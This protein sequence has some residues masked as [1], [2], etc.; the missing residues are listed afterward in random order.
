MSMQPT[1]REAAGALRGRRA[2]LG[3][4]DIH[5]GDDIHPGSQDIGKHR[6]THAY[7]RVYDDGAK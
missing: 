2:G 6:I 7:R 1:A 4:V 3:A 5:R